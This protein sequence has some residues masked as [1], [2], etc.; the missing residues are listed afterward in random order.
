MNLTIRTGNNLDSKST[1]TGNRWFLLSRLC[2]DLGFI[3]G[4]ETLM[5]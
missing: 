5:G 4:K 2:L 1:P 3:E